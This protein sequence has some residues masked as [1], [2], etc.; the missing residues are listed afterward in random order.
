MSY[1]NC[2]PNRRTSA[3]AA[4]TSRST[5]TFRRAGSAAIAL[6]LS[7]LLGCSGSGTSGTDPNNNPDGGGSGGTD[8]LSPTPPPGS[9]RVTVTKGGTGNGVVSSQPA[10]IDCGG[11]CIADFPEGTQITLTPQ[12][13]GA[14]FSGWGGACAGQN[15]VCK[16]TLTANVDVSASFDPLS[17]TPDGICFEAPLPFGYDFNAV[18]AVSATDVWAVGNVGSI[19]RYDGTK[20]KRY[21]AGTT[22][23]L[24]AVWARSANEVYFAANTGGLLR[25]DGTIV[26]K[27]NTSAITT[28]DITGVYGGATNLFV[29]TRS[30]DAWRYN[31]ATWTRYASGTLGIRATAELL[32]VTGTADNDVIVYGSQNAAARWNGSSWAAQPSATLTLS[33][34]SALAQNVYYGTVF[35]GTVWQYDTTKAGFQWKQVGTVVTGT[36]SV[37][38]LY[39]ASASAMFT[40]G[41]TGLI[42]RFDGTK[43]NPIDT[44]IRDV[45]SF[46]A[47]HGTSASDVWAVGRRGTIVHYDGTTTK[48]NRSNLFTGTFIDAWGTDTR[49]VQFLT[50]KSTVVRYDGAAY[51]ESAPLLTGAGSQALTLAGLSANDMWLG[52]QVANKPAILHSTNG[53]AF[54]QLPL[55]SSFQMFATVVDHVFPLSATNAWAAGNPSYN[56]V[57]WDGASWTTDVSY[58]TD[59]PIV[60]LWASGASDVWVASQMKIHR[61]NGSTWAADNRVT[62]ATLYSLH[63]SSATDVWAGDIRAVWRY[64]GTNWTKVT[65]PGSTGTVVGIRALSSTDAWISDNTGALFHWDGSSFKRIDIGTRDSGVG[66]HIWAADPKNVWF[67]GQGIVSYR[68]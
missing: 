11:T 32:A 49:N 22:A 55:D 45:L 24:L 29:T 26:T 44:G 10:G 15:G 8:M 4:A 63:G 25:F 53:G 51:T 36:N 37:T 13:Q 33:Y 62:G 17:C 58:I 39:G 68:K 12:G 19:L 34:I 65:I 50:N 47:L 18:F 41:P 28:G 64:N 67:A 2:S 16:L 46:T 60:G 31:G 52:G 14:A 23:D 5:G 1:S 56:L 48:S 43:W 3:G 59:S 21:E 7:T 42:Y 40:S 30:S 27:V 35:D 61:Y 6:S 20:W 66:M 9:H 38:G 57:H 54:S